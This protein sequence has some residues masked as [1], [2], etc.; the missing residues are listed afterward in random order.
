MEPDLYRGVLIG[1]F[2]AGTVLDHPDPVA[3]S[4]ATRADLTTL[5]LRDFSG[6]MPGEVF[7]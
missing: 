1:G 3:I 7:S 4:E 6:L 5:G 2:I